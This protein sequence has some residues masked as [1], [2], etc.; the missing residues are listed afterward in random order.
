MEIQQKKLSTRHTFTFGDE[1]FN[2]AYK[3]KTGAGDVDLNY[4]GVPQKCSLRI[5]GND[6][7]RN[8]GILWCA[9]GA[10]QLGIAISAGDPLSGKGFWLL[11]GI[12]CLAAHRFA[13][14]KYSVFN[15]DGGNVF[16][17]QDKKH[18]QIVDELLKR[19]KLQ[20][21]AWH[22][23]INLQ[24]DP[25]REV[26]KFNWLHAQGVLSKQ[27]AEAKIAQVELMQKMTHEGP[28]LLN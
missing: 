14:V 22:G 18:K 6:W 26:Q 20:L 7:L 10:L 16:V 5:E 2:F 24:N 27:E 4:A 8:V 13:K 3:D 25:E 1:T 21:L 28:R 12:L 19:R 15:C 9:L 11:V 23:D 17:I